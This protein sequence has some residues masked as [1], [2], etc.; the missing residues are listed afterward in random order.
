[1]ENFLRKF[2]LRSERGEELNQVKRRS[3]EQVHMTHATEQQWT[4]GR[5]VWLELSANGRDFKW[6]SGVSRE[7][8]HSE[9]WG[10]TRMKAQGR[11]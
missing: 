9:L 8:S 7:M 2:Q 3:D 6:E 1:M 5:E 4:R 11:E 10:K